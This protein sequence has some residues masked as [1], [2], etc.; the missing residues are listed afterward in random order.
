MIQVITRALDIL[1]FVAQHGK[2]PVQLI[3][4]AAHVNL[5]QPTCANIVKTLVAKNYL[6]NVSRQTG[7]RLGSGAYQLTGNLSYSQNL[8]LAAKDIME[9]L[10]SKINETS[11]LGI[12]RNNK[13]HLIHVVQSD[14]DLLVRTRQESEIYPTASGRLLMAY[15]PPKELENLIQAIGLPTN[16]VWPEIKS[17]DDLLQALQKIK[18]EEIVQTLS[19]KHIIGIAVPVYKNNSLAAALS[20][21]LPESRFNDTHRD[22][23]LKLLKKATKDIQKRIEKES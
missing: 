21:F 12:L 17:K 13:R 3:K 16:N 4:I 2:E 18:Q 7:Y 9:D 5:S 11:L 20:V 8:I 19:P 6:E 15:L 23:I 10:S 22:K 1:N 14:Q